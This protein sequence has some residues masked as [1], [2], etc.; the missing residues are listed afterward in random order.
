M[1][2][3]LLYAVLMLISMMA[4]ASVVT[5][6]SSLPVRGT[7][8]ASPMEEQGEAVPDDTVPQSR[9]KIQKTAPVLTEDLDSSALDLRMPDNV[10]QRA[11]RACGKG[12]RLHRQDRMGYVKAKRNSAQAARCEQSGGTGLD[13][14]DRA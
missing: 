5:L 9:W 7:G 1:K 6:R 12:H 11:Y 13:I 4:L 3:L 10:K 2:R 14:Q 8:E